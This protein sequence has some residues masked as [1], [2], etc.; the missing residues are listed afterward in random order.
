MKVPVKRKLT[1]AEFPEFSCSAG[2]PVGPG[3]EAQAEAAVAIETAR[4]RE[5]A[6]AAL[7]AHERGERSLVGRRPAC[8]GGDERRDERELL[9]G[10]P[11]LPRPPARAPDAE[12][13]A[14]ARRR[15]PRRRDAVAAELTR[16]ET[17]DE[18]GH[19]RRAQAM[20]RL[21]VPA[22][23]REVDLAAG[24]SLEHRDRRP[25]RPVGGEA[26]L[27]TGEHAEHRRVARAEAEPV[28]EI[29]RA[30]AQ[31]FRALVAELVAIDDDR[32]HPEDPAVSPQ[33]L[34]REQRRL[35]LAERGEDVD[36]EVERAEELPAG[37]VRYGHAVLEG[38][39]RVV[40]LEREAEARRDPEE[41]EA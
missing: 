18:P 17:R 11:F 32:P 14:R 2:S 34:G 38:Q 20:L 16:D 36:G 8:E 12:H 25:V 10:A 27:F 33:E 29:E 21:G 19:V 9:E 39:K 6:R 7:G 15:L 23:K 37:A 22:R 31:R 30:R 5:L 1:P 41:R 35:P 26:R 13:A 24:Q 4:V 28:I 3:L 40:A